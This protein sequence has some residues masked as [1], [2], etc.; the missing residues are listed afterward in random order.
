[1]LNKLRLDQTKDYEVAIAVNKVSTMLVAFINGQS[2]CLSIGSEQGGVQ[3]WDDFV[4]E[5]QNDKYEHLQVKR[6]NTDFSNDNAD[7]DRYIQGPRAGIYRDLSPFDDS[8]KSLA[9]YFGTARVN[10]NPTKF[11]SFYGPS[12]N[13]NIK[14][15]LPLRDLQTFCVSHLTSS[16]TAGGLQALEQESIQ[17]EKLFKWL[18]TWCGF[19]DHAHILRAMKY[20]TIT[21]SGDEG[22]LNT[23]SKQQL[24]LCFSEPDDVLRKVVGYINENTSFTSSITPRPLLSHLTTHLLPSVNLWTQ[25]RNAGTDW[26]VSGTHDREVDAIERATAVVPALWEPVGARI[27][28]Y[29]AQD[30]GVGVLPQAITRL[31]LHFQQTAVAHINNLSS[32]RVYVKGLIGSTL[33]IGERDC[34]TLSAVDDSTCHAPANS[35]SLRLL[36]EHEGE[37]QS[38]SSEMHSSTWTMVRNFV[39]QKIASMSS[40]GL[41][42]A[43]EARWSLWKSALNDDADK[44]KALFKSMLHP[45]AEGEDIIAEL[46]IGP[47]TA[48]IISNGIY[49]LL[50]VVVG[51]SDTDNGWTTVDGQLTIDVKALSHWSGPA[52]RPRRPRRLIDNGI[53][54]LIGKEPSKILILSSVE[55]PSAYILNNS[56]ADGHDSFN[57]LAS[58]RKP[59]LLVTNSYQISQLIE[60][61]NI[62]EIRDYLNSEL[63][64]KLV[65]NA[66][67]I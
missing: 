32:W 57:S 66:S 15:G 67:Q 44:Q 46:R 18:R 63:Q 39:D 5:H 6:Q 30:Y 64:K 37:A 2:H 45:Q 33:G 36:D 62:Q 27:L 47:K 60:K 31:I 34:E 7:R 51:L 41:R 1:M 38:L 65:S 35:R 22:E 61:G 11:F 4:I 54:H 56:L 59:S 9:D 48:F 20:F 21:Q 43:V 19:T 14:A 16:T 26:E 52:G 10:T 49:L 50:V 8:M 55:T 13:I 28:K 42:T 40:S 3:K 23:L 58:P 24:A 12:F 29:H 17:M 25:F 53:D